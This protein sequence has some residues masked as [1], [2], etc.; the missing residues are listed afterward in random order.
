M[1]QHDE[2]GPGNLSTKR[3]LD[4]ARLHLNHP[5]KIEVRRSVGAGVVWLVFAAILL[6]LGG[7]CLYNFGREAFG[8]LVTMGLLLGG[9]WNLIWGLIWVSDRSPVLTL[10]DK[11]LL[12]SRICPETLIP[13]TI[14]RRTTLSRTTR[15]GAEESARLTLFLSQP[16]DGQYELE[17]NLT[18]LDCNAQEIF[19]VIGRRADLE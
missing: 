13:W 4:L 18:N 17:I 8:A 15:N 6:T 2:S 11:G 14:I 16:V 10:G 3:L 7:L 12:D 9:V 19:R 5:Y 1:S